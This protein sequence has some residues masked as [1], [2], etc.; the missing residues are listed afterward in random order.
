MDAQIGELLKA[1]KASEAEQVMGE[2]EQLGEACLVFLQELSSD[3][4]SKPVWLH[5]QLNSDAATVV[6]FGNRFYD[7]W[8]T[9]V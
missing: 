5:P 3:P 4:S 8:A 2:Q 7:N 6:E 9:T 1:G